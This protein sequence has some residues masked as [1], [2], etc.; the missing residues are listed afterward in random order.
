MTF[1]HLNTGNI[2]FSSTSHSLES[3]TFTQSTLYPT[4]WVYN[5]KVFYTS[6]TSTTLNVKGVIK[7]TENESELK[8]WIPCKFHFP[9]HGARFLYINFHV[10]N[11]CS[12]RTRGKEHTKFHWESLL[13]IL[14]HSPHPQWYLNILYYSYLFISLTPLLDC[15]IL[16][17]DG[18]CV[19]PALFPQRLEHSSGWNIC[20]INERQSISGFFL[21][22]SQAI[23]GGSDLFTI[24]QCSS[25]MSGNV[26]LSPKQFPK[27]NDKW[28]QIL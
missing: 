16:N 21:L 27:E 17:K 11:T 28:N 4:K 10:W 3:T 23:L 12:S 8:V 22:G 7:I 18:K 20:R 14:H 25:W 13:W 1:Y 15:R 19:F 24:S 26:T 6:K 5:E 9:L 2:N